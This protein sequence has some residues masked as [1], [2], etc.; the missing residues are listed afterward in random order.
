MYTGDNKQVEY[1]TYEKREVTSSYDGEIRM[2]FVKKVYSLLSICVL[3]TFF[4]CC[5]SM[6][7][8]SYR[9]FQQHDIA[10]LITAI[11]VSL[12]ILICVFCFMENLRKVP[13]NYLVLFSFTMCQS[14]IVSYM[15]STTDPQIVLIA[16]IMTVCLVIALTVYASYTNKDFTLISG[17]L[18]SLIISLF[19]FTLF[20][21]ILRSKIL[22]I[23]AAAFGIFVFSLYIIYDTQLILGRHKH[24]LSCDDYILG[25]LVL[26]ID[27]IALF[28]DIIACLNCC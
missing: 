25:V 21:I 14:Y 8:E 3:I 10:V 26:Y 12:A 28:T 27:I 24:K 15:C 22:Y 9:T 16:T 2:D 4:A 17:F 19:L 7:N 5:L 6:F 11:V 23:L 1:G 13:Y 18:F 20:A